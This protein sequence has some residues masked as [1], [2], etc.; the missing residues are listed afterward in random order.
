MGNGKGV[1]SPWPPSPRGNGLRFFDGQ[2]AISSDWSKAWVSW[3]RVIVPCLRI[4]I[5]AP[6]RLITVEEAPIWQGPESIIRS[7][8]LPIWSAASYAVI[9]AGQPDMF[10]LV[11]TAGA[12]SSF[13]IWSI[14]AW[15]GILTPTVSLPAVTTSDMDGFL[16]RTI[17]SG[18]G[19]K[20]R[21]NMYALSGGF[22]VT[23]GNIV[24][25]AIWTGRGVSFGRCL[26]VNTERTACSLL[27]IVPSP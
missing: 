7:T 1:Q 2:G 9:G 4:F 23:S 21:A 16:G 15:S 10:A 3:D 18:P 5:S 13:S 11:A 22:S 24:M 6:V 19:Q 14:I 25:S 12:F 8:L 26:A 20:V 17:V 27:A